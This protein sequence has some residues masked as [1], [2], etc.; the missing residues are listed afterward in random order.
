MVSQGRGTGDEFQTGIV[1]GDMSSS[2]RLLS[3]PDYKIL[4][5]L[6]EGGLLEDTFNY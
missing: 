1:L 6:N 3:D 4:D 5:G 2:S